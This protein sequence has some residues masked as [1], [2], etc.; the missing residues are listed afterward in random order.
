[1]SHNIYYV[2]FVVVFL[3]NILLQLQQNI[4]IQ[5]IKSVNV[6]NF[7]HNYGFKVFI[8]C[9]FDTNLFRM[10]GNQ[11]RIRTFGRS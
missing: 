7:I 8:L 11:Q 4:S 9:I 10:N 6:E 1:V 3:D 5:Q 2:K